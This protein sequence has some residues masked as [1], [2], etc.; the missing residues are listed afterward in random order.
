MNMHKLCAVIACLLPVTALGQAGE[1]R[2]VQGDAKVER[3]GGK[4]ELLE[5]GSKLAEGDVVVTGASA[6]IQITMIDDAVVAVRPNT[7]LKIEAYRYAGKADGSETGIFNLLRG[8]FRS[9]TG[10][11]GKQN[12]NAYSVRTPS[13]TIGIRGTDHEP[14][15][16]PVP[17]AGE[18]PIGEPG[19]Y[20]KV[21]SGSTIIQTSNGNLQL[22]TNQ[23]GFAPA[24]PGSPPITLVQPPPFMRSTPPIQ[25]GGA[26]QSGQQGTSSAA[27][28]PP[29]PAIQP[30]GNDSSATSGNLASLPPPPL[31]PLP[32][33][34]TID[35]YSIPAG[36]K[37]SPI[38]TV[39]A[40]GDL[41]SGSVGSGAG[42]IGDPKDNFAALVDSGGNLIALSSTNFN[43]S[44][45]SAPLVDSGNVVIGSHTINW[46]V[47]A[48]GSI[49]D[50]GIVRIPQYFHY[51]IGGE[52]STS[53]SLFSLM[54]NPGDPYSF[55]S[56]SGFTK[57]ISESGAVG[58][59]VDSISITL[60]NLGGAIH[61]YTY[62]L[63][64]TDAHGR[65]WNG[66]LTTPQGLA[67]FTHNPGQNL[68]VS[69]PS[70]PAGPATG[71]AAGMAIGNPVS[72]FVSSYSMK[73]GGAGVTGA[74]AATPSM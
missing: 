8:G 38:G 27:T 39:L 71:Q 5:R 34:G 37:A 23:I 56:V 55:D 57:P 53:A 26:N 45:D 10:L 40:G 49:N 30:A 64:V 41:S 72:G 7:R 59:S 35:P 16:I 63:S 29:P 74:V 51:M 46:G 24:K 11:I 68:T 31:A 1:V 66:N 44:R 67:T 32:Q 48:G 12:K 20:D 47:Y 22:Q 33:P 73:Q 9:I 62:D 6:N 70:C 42:I 21:N 65:N 61:V 4:T 43:Y 14:L 28:A 50:N 3:A 2:F 69:C 52:A 25:P 13:A 15:V 58:G 36:A 60:K 19:T 54:P 17:V 18:T